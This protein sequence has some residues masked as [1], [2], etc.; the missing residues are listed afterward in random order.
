MWCLRDFLNV[1]QKPEYTV[2]LTFK[3]KHRIITN[4]NRCVKIM[5]VKFQGSTSIPTKCSSIKAP[6]RMRHFS[7]MAK[8]F[9]LWL[10]FVFEDASHFFN[11]MS[12]LLH[13]KMLIGRTLT[14]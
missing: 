7:E 10:Q 5:D 4:T 14:F 12:F 13:K 9:C 11:H 3:K 8:K 6:K 2:G 1:V